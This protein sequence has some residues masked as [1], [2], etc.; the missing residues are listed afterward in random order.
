M[1]RQDWTNPPSGPAP[2]RLTDAGGDDG[3]GR[4]LL[5]EMPPQGG[6]RHGVEEGLRR[7][8]RQGRLAPGTRLPATRELAAQLGVARGTVTAAYEQLVAEGW[9]TART[10]AGTW[11]A[12]L[13]VAAPGPTAGEP[14][15]AAVPVYRHDLAPGRP[16]VSGFPR[17]AWAAAVRRA[18]THAPAEAFGYG[19]P[20][21]RIELRRALADYLGRVRGVRVDPAN[22]IVC[23]GYTQALNLLS[24]VL[25][26]VGVRVVAME[27]PALGDYVRV[28]SSRLTVVDLPVDSAGARV[29]DL[30]G[31]GAQAV[32][33]TPAHQFPLGVSL[34]APRRAALLAWAA[35]QH[36]WIV[37]DDYD[38]EFRYDRRPVGAVQ[39]HLPARVIYVGS[40]SK[41]LGPAVRLGWIACPPQLRESLTELK[42]LTDRQTSPID[43]L[44]LASLLDRGAYDRHL[45]LMRR[46]YRQRR[47]LLGSAV[48]E[49]L[50]QARLLGIS[51]G[52][53]AILQLPAT[54]PD[55]EQVLAALAERGVRVHGLGR[56]LR[57][58]RWASPALV[59]GYGTPPAHGYRAAVDAL[60]HGLRDILAVPGQPS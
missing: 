7:A 37:E 28:M 49:R 34:S 53:H 48:A 43:Q 46:S 35:R 31:L 45:R 3:V 26:D 16:D 18:L 13:M 10:G 30:E 59:V 2:P 60:I 39:A 51:A 20:R 56:Y 40:T 17:D 54:A 8:I 33:C 15:P 27:D 23:S 52:L 5:I 11:V 24:A 29:G 47:D 21:G 14:E 58:R 9:L 1:T 41:S 25:A 22:L 57:S 36:G 32:G 12:D 38:S 19:D 55:E 50:P 42:W 6:R 44:A 4:E